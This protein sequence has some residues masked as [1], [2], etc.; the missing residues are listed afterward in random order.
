[1]MIGRRGRNTGHG[2]AGIV[3]VNLVLVIAVAPRTNGAPAGC[4]QF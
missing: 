3:G 4:N 1:M 2:D